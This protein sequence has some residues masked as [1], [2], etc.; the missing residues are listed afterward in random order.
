MAYSF[1]L[2]THSNSINI[3]SKIKIGFDLLIPRKYGSLKIEDENISEK[4]LKACCMFSAL[5]NIHAKAAS[6]NVIPIFISSFKVGK[7]FP[8]QQYLYLPCFYSSTTMAKNKE[9][10]E[11]P[12]Q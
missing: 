10:A 11:A 12:M 1:S 3:N 2:P 7:K 9:H 4:Q 5:K 6:I 8:E